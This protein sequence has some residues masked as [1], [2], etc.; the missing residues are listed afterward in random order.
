LLPGFEEF[1]RISRNVGVKKG[2]MLQSARKKRAI[3]LVENIVLQRRTSVF[4]FFEDDE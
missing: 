4:S 1:E 2:A 3:S